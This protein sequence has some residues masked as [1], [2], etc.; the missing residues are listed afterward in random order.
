[1]GRLC[2]RRMVL[3]P[4]KRVLGRW[5]LS[6]R[7][8]RRQRPARM[9]ERRARVCGCLR[10]LDGDEKVRER[11]VMVMQPIPACQEQC[12]RFEQDTGIR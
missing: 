9:N 7:V 3:D 8:R 11:A 12:P 10:L 1:M 4:V 2:D 5:K 6:F